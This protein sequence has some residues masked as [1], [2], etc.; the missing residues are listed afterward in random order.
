MILLSVQTYTDYNDFHTWLETIKQRYCLKI[1]KDTK[2]KINSFHFMNSTIL[3]LRHTYKL[4]FRD[5]Y[6]FSLSIHY[7][8]MYIN[9]VKNIDLLCSTISKIVTSLIQ[10]NPFWSDL[11]QFNPLRFNLTQ[12]TIPILRQHIFGLFLTHS[13]TLL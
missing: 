8:P 6:T 3:F 4:L 13:P 5:Y 1:E 12:G 2:G 11:I 9:R 10:F 7:I